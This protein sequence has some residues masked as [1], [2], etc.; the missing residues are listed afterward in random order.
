[1]LKESHLSVGKQC[2]NKNENSGVCKFES[3]YVRP[4]DRVNDSSQRRWTCLLARYDF[5]A[6]VV[7]T[8]VDQNYEAGKLRG[9]RKASIERKILPTQW[10]FD[11][12]RVRFVRIFFTL[13]TPSTRLANLPVTPRFR[14]EFV[15]VTFLPET[16]RQFRIAFQSTAARSSRAMFAREWL[17][18]T[19]SRITHQ[20]GPR[21]RDN[22]L[23]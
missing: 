7:S 21:K 16:R 3:S 13:L 12:T 10:L 4:N 11:F 9:K 23:A 2:K 17:R 8:F 20:V 18:P 14:I 19:G 15:C 22:S 1:M 6:R 5:I